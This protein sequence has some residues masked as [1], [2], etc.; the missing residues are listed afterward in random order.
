MLRK[1]ADLPE[2]NGQVLAKHCVECAAFILMLFGTQYADH[3]TQ[4]ALTD[5]NAICDPDGSDMDV[6]RSA[7][8][9]V[10]CVAFA[11]ICCLL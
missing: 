6:C 9:K 11:Y 7:L 3:P 8:A 10:S 1:A 2:G 5:L 4:E